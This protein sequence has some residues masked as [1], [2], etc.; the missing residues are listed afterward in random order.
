ME[1]N[2]KFLLE[3]LAVA[4]IASVVIITLATPRR[5][6]AVSA[7]TAGLASVS[8]TGVGMTD[9]NA[10]L[11]QMSALRADIVSL[12]QQMNVVSS[13]CSLTNAKNIAPAK[14]AR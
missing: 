5:E 8:Q 13:V 1:T 3:V 7:R 4:S 2:N 14:D 11:L 10:L 12:R 9:T 6:P